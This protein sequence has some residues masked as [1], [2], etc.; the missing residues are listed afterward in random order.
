M[1]DKI[2]NIHDE[3]WNLG[4]QLE[5]GG[6]PIVTLQDVMGLIKLK[7]IYYDFLRESFMIH[8]EISFEP[9]DPIILCRWNL[10]EYDSIELYSSMRDAVLS[11]QDE[12]THLILYEAIQGIYNPRNLEGKILSKPLYFLNKDMLI[13]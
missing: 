4:Q 3:I 12:M 5:S 7:D 13:K 2:K 8:N 1:I 11:D 9:C 6:E 10:K